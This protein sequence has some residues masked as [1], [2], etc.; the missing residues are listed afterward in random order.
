MATSRRTQPGECHDLGYSQVLG[1]SDS[2]APVDCSTKHTT[3]TI[4]VTTVPESVWDRRA[5]ERRLY[6]DRACF[7]ARDDYFEVDRDDVERTLF[8]QPVI[9]WPTAAE[10]TAGNASSGVTLPRSQAAR[11]MRSLPIR[12]RLTLPAAGQEVEA[13]VRR[14]RVATGHR[15]PAVSWA[16]WSWRNYSL[17][18]RYRLD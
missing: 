8:R 11:C 14:C 3:M 4:R 18:V 15:P 10:I 17:A 12:A 2:S 1:K 6:V 5:E 7:E 13:S 16:S 9:F